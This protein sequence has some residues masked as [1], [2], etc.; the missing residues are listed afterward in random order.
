MNLEM[1][2]HTKGFER[3][4][5][6]LSAFNFIVLPFSQM[7]HGVFFVRRSLTCGYERFAFQAK[8]KWQ[9]AQKSNRRFKN[10]M[11]FQKL[12]ELYNFMNFQL[13]NCFRL[14][15]PNFHNRRIHSAEKRLPHHLL[16]ERQNK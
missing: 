5:E 7:L 11:T 16:P 9:V 13:S 12:D 10:L 4:R 1:Q 15:K 2:Y 14:E 6:V 8:P 3:Q